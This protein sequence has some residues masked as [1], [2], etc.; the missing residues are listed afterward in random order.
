MEYED[1]TTI[2]EHVAKNQ[3]STIQHSVNQLVVLT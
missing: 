1:G 3:E 2:A